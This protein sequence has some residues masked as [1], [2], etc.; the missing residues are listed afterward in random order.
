M[1]IEALWRYAVV[2]EL[3]TADELK[4]MIE[5]TLA[6]FDIGNFGVHPTPDGKSWHVI[7]VAH[8]TEHAGDA[9]A[10]AERR[11]TELR[12]KFDLRQ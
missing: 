12:E 8:G 6:P 10:A 9:H 1:L 2:K 3:K 11:A 5:P 7:V 4:A